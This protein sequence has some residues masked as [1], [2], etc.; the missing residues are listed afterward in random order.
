MHIPSLK[1]GF[2][3]WRDASSLSITI[4][5]TDSSPLKIN[6]WKTTF[7]LGPGLFLGGK[8]LASGRLFRVCHNHLKQP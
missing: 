1:L 3:G 6:G 8:L 7:L 4:P 5:E 2:G